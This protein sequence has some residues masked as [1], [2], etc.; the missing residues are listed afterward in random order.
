[1]KDTYEACYGSTKLVR[2]GKGESITV[3]TTESKLLDN[4][5]EKEKKKKKKCCLKL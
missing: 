4:K 2:L 1:M 5:D 3:E